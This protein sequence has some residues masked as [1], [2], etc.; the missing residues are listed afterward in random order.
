MRES[1]VAEERLRSSRDSN[2]PS[3][4]TSVLERL[5]RQT[6]LCDSSGLLG[7]TAAENATVISVVCSSLAISYSRVAVRQPSA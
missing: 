5:L 1:R 4:Y 2:A 7:S 3:G 6:K